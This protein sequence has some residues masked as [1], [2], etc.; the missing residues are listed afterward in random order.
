MKICFIV[1]LL[2]LV[3][4]INAQGYTRYDS[5]L[6]IGKAGFKIFCLNKSPDR[7]SLTIRP[8]GFKSEAREVSLEIKARVVSAEIDDLN[9]DGFPEVVIFILEPKGN[10]SLFCISSKENER[11]EPIF[12][13][14]ITDDMRLSKGYRG[15]D[16]FKLV[17]G[18]LFRKFPIFE[19]DTTIKQPT[20][21]VRQILYRVIPG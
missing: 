21:K 6:K 18:V 4:G 13:P 16:E 11:M 12:F 20:G 5:T 8:I 17:E 3:H 9:N 19:S 1:S 10:K 15:Q 14:D 2:F 7:N